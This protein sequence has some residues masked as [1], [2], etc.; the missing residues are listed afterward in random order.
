MKRRSRRLRLTRTSFGTFRSVWNPDVDALPGGKI[1]DV[2][3]RQI[4]GKEVVVR[5]A[6]RVLGE[7]EG[8]VVVGPDEPGDGARLLGGELPRVILAERA[9]PYL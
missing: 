6:V 8:P 5:V 9:D 2:A 1:A 4:D 7:E 3:R